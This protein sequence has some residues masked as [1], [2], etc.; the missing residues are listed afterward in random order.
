MESHLA[1][2]EIISKHNQWNVE[3]KTDFLKCSLS[4]EGSH[5]L[6][7]IKD[8]ASY[9]DVVCKLRQRYGTL[10]RIE[11]FRMELKTRKRHPG[12]PLSQLLKDMRRLFMQAYPGP[13]IYI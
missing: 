6:R 11:S 2:F 13:G 7:D 10:E 8:D 5:I 4:G 1:Q 9:D 12:E 3:E